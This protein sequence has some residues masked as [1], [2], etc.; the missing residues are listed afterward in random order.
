[1]VS[2]LTAEEKDYYTLPLEAPALP[3]EG[4]IL[5]SR[6]PRTNTI[7][8]TYYTGE[9]R[10]FNAMVDQSQELIRAGIPEDKLTKVLDLAWNI[11]YVYV[12]TPD[13]E[14]VL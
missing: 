10:F 13:Y 9:T 14:P 11:I 4:Q 1:M 3:L 7:K 2:L 5:V 6:L 8:I 12:T